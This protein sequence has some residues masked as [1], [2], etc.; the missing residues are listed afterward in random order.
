MMTQTDDAGF[1]LPEDYISQKL[2]PYLEEVNNALEGINIVLVL[3]FG[4][5]MFTFIFLIH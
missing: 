1:F 4:I 3:P 5:L 2:Q